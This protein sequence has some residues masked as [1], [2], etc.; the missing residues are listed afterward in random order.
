[1]VIAIATDDDA[2]DKDE[3]TNLLFEGGA[4]EI[5]ERTNNGYEDFVDV[6]INRAN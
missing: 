3:L 4:V 2:I 5:K 6:A 1:M